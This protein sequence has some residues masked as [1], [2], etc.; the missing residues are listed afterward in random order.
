[1]GR[2]RSF[3]VIL[4][5]GLFL[6]PASYPPGWAATKP[7]RLILWAWERPEDLTFIDPGTTDVAF[8]AA[9][10]YLGG[11][12]V[13]IRPRLQPLK[14]PKGTSPLAVVRIEVDRSRPPLLTK[15]QETLTVELL[16]G[17]ARKPFL[18]GLQVDFDA[19]T[20]QRIFYMRVL[21]SVRRQMPV[22][23]KLGIT[24]L[25]SWC[26]DDQWACNLPVDERVLMLFRMG[27][28]GPSVLAQLKKG[29]RFCPVCTKSIGLSVDEPTTFVPDCQRLYVFNPRPWTRDELT[30]LEREV[31][32]VR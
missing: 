15:K 13:N 22:G 24:C 7:P 30:R 4:F 8:L 1:M 23:R 28:E 21:D 29:R 3:F 6:A 14:L 18:A 25:A 20:S 16:L 32:H 17:V 19:T 5:L 2:L 9:T 27:P 11:E 12:E 31:L 10:V 26:L